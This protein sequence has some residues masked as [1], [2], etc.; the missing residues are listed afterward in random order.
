VSYYFAWDDLE[1]EILLSTYQLAG[2]TGINPI[3]YF[4]RAFFFFWL[5]KPVTLTSVLP[6]G[7]LLS[8]E[9]MRQ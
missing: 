7:N 9:P 8:T 1:L 3:Q 5:G 4:L 6:F 2:I